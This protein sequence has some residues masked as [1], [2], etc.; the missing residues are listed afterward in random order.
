MFVCAMA[1]AAK[2]AMVENGFCL[3]GIVVG[4]HRQRCVEQAMP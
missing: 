3:L 4:H 2:K 1:L